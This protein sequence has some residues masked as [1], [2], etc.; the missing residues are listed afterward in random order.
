MNTIIK[1]IKRIFE[2]FTVFNFGWDM[3]YG[4]SL[5]ILETMFDNLNANNIKDIIQERSLFRLDISM[6]RINYSILYSKLKTI[7]L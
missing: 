2:T 5:I 3:E 7:E 1:N 6:K 4:F